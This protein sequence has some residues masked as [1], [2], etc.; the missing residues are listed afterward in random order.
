MSP[1]DR[2]TTSPGTRSRIGTSRYRALRVQRD[3]EGRRRPPGTSSRRSGRL[4]VAVVLTIALS[5]SA[6][7]PERY[8]WTKRSSTLTSTITAD[9]DG[10]LDVVGDEGDDGQGQQQQ[11]ERVVEGV[12]ELDV[13]ARRPLVGHFVGA[14]PRP[15][16][17]RLSVAESGRRRVEQGH[18][19]VKVAPR[20]LDHPR[21]LSRAARGGFRSGARGRVAGDPQQGG[22]E[23]GVRHDTP[24]LLSEGGGKR[25]EAAQRGDAGRVGQ[26]RLTLKPYTNCNRSA[27]GRQ[28]IVPARNCAENAGISSLGRVA[29][30]K[31]SGQIA[32][33]T[34]R[35]W[36]QFARTPGRGSGY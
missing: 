4:T 26:T 3:A 22:L 23:E 11:D 16:Q 32:G 6:A 33:A 31:A 36:R 27:G 35:R 21:R 20:F 2:W 17:R 9:D 24:F 10:P 13:P 25:A 28:G 15:A 8:S 18:H 19:H 29:R 5:F 34:G 7:W 12:Q 30:Q 14:V 1:A